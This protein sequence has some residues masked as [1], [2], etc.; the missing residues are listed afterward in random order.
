MG[1]IQTSLTQIG[2]SLSESRSKRT[3]DFFFMIDFAF[4]FTSFSF[5][6][7]NFSCP[8]DF[9]FRL[10][11]L[12]FVFSHSRQLTQPSLEAAAPHTSENIV[13]LEAAHASHI[14]NHHVQRAQLIYQRS[15]RPAVASRPMVGQ[16][17]HLEAHGGSLHVHGGSLHMGTAAAAAGGSRSA[18]CGPVDGA[19]FW[20]AADPATWV[21]CRLRGCADSPRPFTRQRP[22]IR[23]P[24][25]FHRKRRFSAGNMTAG[26]R[27]LG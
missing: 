12:F 23:S 24:V 26:N 21:F 8:S 14:G 9:C 7:C 20:P 13:P 6:F 4:M 15:R 2:H 17:Q 22:Q 11:C 25:V 3:V 1:G 19:Q 18:G 10:L 16:S 27:R 5:I